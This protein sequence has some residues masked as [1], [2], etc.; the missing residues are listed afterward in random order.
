LVAGRDFNQGDQAAAQKVVIVSESM[1]RLFWPGEN[2]IGKCVIED[3]RNK[4]CSIVVGVTGDVHQMEVI[5]KP[6]MRYFVPLAQARLG[7]AARFIVVRTISPHPGD[8]ERVAALELKRALPTMTTPSIVPMSQSLER[9]FRPWQLGA[10]LFTAF[11]ILALVVAAIGI[12]SVVAYAVSQRTHELGVRIALGARVA[13]LLE[14]V[15]GESFK[16]VA[17]GIVIGV[18]ASLALGKLVASLLYGLS[19]RDPLVVAGSALVLC[20]IG[21]GASL[22]PAWRAARV[23]PVTALRMD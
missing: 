20:A 11:G 16:V 22:I 1:A 8:V 14:L 19:P 15:V 4:P 9:Q 7:T 13:D 17:I 6:T 5:E 21:I 23:D 2:P 3:A 10:T 18:L 12:Y